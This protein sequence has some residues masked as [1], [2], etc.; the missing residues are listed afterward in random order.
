MKKAWRNYALSD[1]LNSNDKNKKPVEQFFSGPG[2]TSISPRVNKIYQK[3]KT[4]KK[5]HKKP[6]ANPNTIVLPLI[7]KWKL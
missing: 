1:Y 3:Y 7:K 6:K 2:F 5:I 4:T